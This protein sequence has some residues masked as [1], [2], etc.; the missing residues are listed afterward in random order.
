[1]NG[2]LSLNKEAVSKVMR[3]DSSRMI[4]I[5]EIWSEASILVS[6]THF[7]CK[8]RLTKRGFKFSVLQFVASE[9][10]VTRHS[11]V[12]RRVFANEDVS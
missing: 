7:N 12:K 9:L 10:S 5:H 3:T 2:P 4:H 6:H 11:E 8:L 1:M